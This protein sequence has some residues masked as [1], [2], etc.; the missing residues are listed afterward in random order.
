MKRL[1]SCD[2][3]TG[4]GMRC[5]CGLV[6]NPQGTYADYD[7]AIAFAKRCLDIRKH[8]ERKR[9]LDIHV[10]LSNDEIIELA[11]KESGQ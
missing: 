6:E 2:C 8:Q 3:D 4:Y 1:G 9:Q 7:D 11:L 5:Q 10:P